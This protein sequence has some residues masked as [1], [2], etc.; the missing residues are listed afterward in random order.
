[1]YREPYK[2][3]T[4]IIITKQ[5]LFIVYQL[6]QVCFTTILFCHQTLR[7]SFILY[8]FIDNDEFYRDRDYFIYS[9]VS[10][11]PTYKTFNNTSQKKG[12][13][14]EI[15]EMACL[16]LKASAIQANMEQI[17]LSSICYYLAV[18]IQ[19]RLFDVAC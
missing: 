10:H 6:W 14:L 19:T 8:T 17:R 9:L 16:Y 13:L 2:L 7:N 4:A 1:M 15:K 12:C 5:N 18:H 11:T 3:Q